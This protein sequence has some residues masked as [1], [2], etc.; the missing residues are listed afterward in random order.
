MS[1]IAYVAK[2]GPFFDRSG[3]RY[4]LRGFIMMKTMKNNRRWKYAGKKVR[5]EGFNSDIDVHL[6]SGTKKGHISLPVVKK[7]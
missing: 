4:S 7:R 6:K 1:R 2:M 5:L 3:K